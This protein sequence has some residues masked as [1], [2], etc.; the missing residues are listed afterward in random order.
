M[1]VLSLSLSGQSSFVK[2]VIRI[3][4]MLPNSVSPERIF[5]FYGLTHTKHR[6]R[7]GPEKV[8][9]ATLVHNDC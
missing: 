7:L 1:V 4:S 6:T 9:D 2:L 5:N 3:I 8:H